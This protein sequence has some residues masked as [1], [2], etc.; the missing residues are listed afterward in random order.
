MARPLDGFGKF[1][2]MLRANAGM[3]GV[4]YLRL[5]RHKTADKI[6]LFIV[7]VVHVLRAEEAL[8]GHGL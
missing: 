1:P 6:H 2:L 5:A 8:F 7:D 3:L 4:N